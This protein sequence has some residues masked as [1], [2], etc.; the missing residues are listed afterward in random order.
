MVA[1][2]IFETWSIDALNIYYQ[3]ILLVLD[4]VLN[5]SLN[6]DVIIEA[7]NLIQVLTEIIP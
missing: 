4:N 3:H 1:I 6:A 5:K 7:L 2:E